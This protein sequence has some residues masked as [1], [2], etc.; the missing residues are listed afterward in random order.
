RPLLGALPTRRPSDLVALT[1]AGL[2]F[3]FVI[4]FLAGL[5]SFIPYVGST[6]GLIA[7]VGLALVQFDE[8]LRVALVAA[9]FFGGQAIEG[10][11]LTDRE[12]TR[13]KSS[14]VKI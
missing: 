8:L 12:S 13:L 3:G 4:G 2:D 10:N 6:F 1:L 14:H 5:V 9:I 11:I 7:S